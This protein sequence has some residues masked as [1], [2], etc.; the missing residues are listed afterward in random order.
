MSFFKGDPFQWDFS[1]W[2]NIKSVAR[3]HVVWYG[4][5]WFGVVWFGVVNVF[6]EGDEWEGTPFA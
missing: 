2:L 3:E 1:D 6:P 4:V 5:V